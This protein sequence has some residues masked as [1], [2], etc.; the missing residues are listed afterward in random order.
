M[1]DFHAQRAEREGI[2]RAVAKA[3]NFMELYG[4]SV[5]KLELTALKAAR[6]GLVSGRLQEWPW[7]R[8]ALLRAG[9]RVSPRARKRVMRLAAW[10]ALGARR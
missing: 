4:G 7:L 6:S 3:R 2:P 1:S 5:P 9:L 8:S 10:I